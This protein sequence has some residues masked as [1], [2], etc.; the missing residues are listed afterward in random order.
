MWTSLLL[1]L[2]KVERFLF[3]LQAGCLYTR[4][5]RSDDATIGFLKLI[6]GFKKQKLLSN[7]NTVQFK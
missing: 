5:N 2:F 7:L 6:P 1:V 3:R 4:S